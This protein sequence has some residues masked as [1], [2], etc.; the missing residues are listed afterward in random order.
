MKVGRGLGLLLLIGLANLLR[1]RFD[2]VEGDKFRLLPS[3][4]PKCFRRLL[5]SSCRDGSSSPSTLV[6]SVSTWE[7]AWLLRPPRVSK[8]EVLRGDDD[9]SGSTSPSVA[10]FDSSES[11]SSVGSR[12]CDSWL[13][14]SKSSSVDSSR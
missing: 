12:C 3:F 10:T 2:V 1:F 8:G 6:L 7:P 4:V 14:G 11:L 9:K 13:S 5:A